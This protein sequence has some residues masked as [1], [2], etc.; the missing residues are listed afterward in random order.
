[1]TYSSDADGSGSKIDTP[2][3]CDRHGARASREVVH[4]VVIGDRVSRLGLAIQGPVAGLSRSHSAPHI[5]AQ[6]T[7]DQCTS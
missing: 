6:Q 1:M 5:E 2:C 3:N 4:T 7:L